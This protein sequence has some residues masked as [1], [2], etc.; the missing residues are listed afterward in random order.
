MGIHILPSS[1]VNTSLQTSDTWLA[2][3]FLAP[4]V[5][6]KIKWFTIKVNT[7]VAHIYNNIYSFHSDDLQTLFPILMVE[8][9]VL[10]M[11]RTN[12]I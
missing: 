2:C 6:Q 9:L 1:S 11:E 3:S 7:S 8:Q 5:E 12:Q 10:S 4:A